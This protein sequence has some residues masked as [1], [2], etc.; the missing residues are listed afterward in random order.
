MGDGVPA[1]LMTFLPGRAVA[2]PNLDRLAEVAA[3]IHDVEPDDLPHDYAPWCRETTKGPPSS[4]T[5]PQLWIDA[6]DRWMNHMPAYHRTFIHRD[7]HPGNVLCRE[8]RARGSSTGPALA[9]ALGAVT[10]PTAAPCSSNSPDRR[11]PTA[12]LTPTSRSPAGSSTPIG[13]SRRSLNTG[14]RIGIRSR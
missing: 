12:F 2:V 5:R 4:A 14:P 13:R 10:S 1:I 6:I 8:G 3:A 11:P 9:E 7:F